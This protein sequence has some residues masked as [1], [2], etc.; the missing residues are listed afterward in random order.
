MDRRLKDKRV[1]F[2]FFILTTIVLISDISDIFDFYLSSLETLNNWRY[3]TSIVN[4]IA[5]PATVMVLIFILFRR[6]KKNKFLWILFI[7]L[8]VE[9]ALVIT[10]PWTH[11]VFFFSADNY[12]HR[13]TIGFLPHIVSGIYLV[14]M[15]VLS[16]V[17]S[18]R[19]DKVELFTIVIVSAI[20]L[21]AT[22][23]E[24]LGQ[25]Q[26]LV[27]SALAVSCMLY[28][29][30]FF[31]RQSRVDQLTGLYNRECFFTETQK[32]SRGGGILISVDLNNL[33]GIN[34]NN[35]H[36]AG[37]EA[38]AALSFCLLKSGEK[39]FLCYRT[40]GDEFVVLGLKKSDQEATRYIASVKELL[41]KTP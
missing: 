27:S 2:L 30:Y 13:G 12:F 33:K 17:F 25:Y 5:N 22:L 11:L 39:G 6:E 7:P 41:K 15:L 8:I 9:A 1:N 36:A 14:A 4:Y 16:F 29:F 38:L 28:Y 3:F 32:I 18:S 23:L 34:D 24:S 26:F 35:G 19:F 40:G 31:L 20:S 10:S 37:D 21:T